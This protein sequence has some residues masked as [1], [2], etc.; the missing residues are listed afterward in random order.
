MSGLMFGMG[1]TLTLDD[2]RRIILLPR[3]T[4][5]GTI[6]Q[7]VGCHSQ[8]WHSLVPSRSSRSSPRVS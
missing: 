5:V 3:P 7:L 6:L 4:M 8:A 2:F 1:L